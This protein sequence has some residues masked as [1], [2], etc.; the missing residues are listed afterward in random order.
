MTKAFLVGLV[1]GFVSLAQT[2]ALPPMQ[3]ATPAQPAN[4]PQANQPTN[5]ASVRPRRR[6]SD[7][8]L[9]VTREAPLP[10][11]ARQALSLSQISVD[12]GVETKQGADGR[13]MLTYG[14]GTPTIVCA[15]LN[16]TEVD[17]ALGET[18]V[19]DGLDLGDGGKEFFV[20]VRHAGSGTN[21]FDYLTIKP[22]SADV[23]MTMTVGTNRRV[24]Y[25]RVRSTEKNHMTRIAFSYPEEEAKARQQMALA[26]SRAQEATTASLPG[27]AT[28]GKYSRLNVPTAP[29]PVVKPWKYTL[30]KKGRDVEYIVPVS[31]GDDGGHTHIELPQEA[32]VRGLPVLQISDATGPIPANTHWENTTLIVDALFEKGCLLEGVGKKQQSVCIYNQKLAK[33]KR[34]G[35]N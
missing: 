10:E 20:T 9:Q 21:A 6:D 18:V 14:T 2:P 12:T 11:S 5:P 28:A 34:S 15:L 32:K 1:F 23:E 27:A 26:L 29:E 19:K 13:I 17:L 16:I 4:A 7:L 24:Y 31:V 33:D 3:Q 30:K 22:I 25:L 35:T 8:P